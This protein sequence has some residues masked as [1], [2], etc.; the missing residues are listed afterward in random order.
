MN[1]NDKLIQD[2]FNSLPLDV[3]ESISRVPWRERVEDIAKRESLDTDKASALEI[4]TM[5]ILFGFENPDN[6]T[7]NIVTQVEIDEGMA[8][9][10][11]KEVSDEIITDIEKQYEM[12]DAISHKDKVKL[13]QT[14]QAPIVS[15]SSQIPGSTNL[16][17]TQTALPTSS[18]L[19]EIPPNILPKIVPGQNVHEVAHVES[20]TTPT[21]PLVPASVP[22]IPKPTIKSENGRPNLEFP[23]SGYARGKDP[24]REPLE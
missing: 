10:I 2:Q 6:Y 23:Q 4:E 1:D 19:P 22:A 11:T 14:T 3:K 5:L 20:S 21:Q 17:P 16:T 15:R 7:Q 18:S 9:R 8:E 13:P 24:Y 12:I